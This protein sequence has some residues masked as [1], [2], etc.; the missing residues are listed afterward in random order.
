LP[1]PEDIDTR[2]MDIAPT[3]VAKLLTVDIEGWKKEV[4]NMR[5][6]FAR[7]GDRLPKGI[8]NEVDALEARL[9]A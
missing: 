1:R 8:T 7:F 6:Y 4:P 5:E 3:T 9:N 2:G